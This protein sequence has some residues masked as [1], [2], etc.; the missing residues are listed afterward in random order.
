M[1]GIAGIATKGRLHGEQPMLRMLEALKQRGPDD[2]GM[3]IGNEAAIGQRRLSIIDLE[4]GHQPIPNEDETLWL[5]CN[6]EIYN[7]KELRKDL[8]RRGHTFLTHSDSEVIL[9][10]YE[11]KGENCVDDLRGM[12]SFAI[13]DQGARQ[14]FAA[15]DRLGQKPFYYVNN[16]DGFFFASEIKALLALEPAWA[17][18]DAESLDQYFTLRI[19]APPQSVSSSTY[20]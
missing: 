7:Y 3:Y 1:C 4:G 20:T 18:M 13:W 15:R 14:F 8:I 17:E 2:S 5:V 6:G 12:F 16:A 10:L 11:E 9:H 19:I